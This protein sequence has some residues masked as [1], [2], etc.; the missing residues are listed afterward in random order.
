[1]IASYLSNN[2]GGQIYENH[3]PTKNSNCC[4]L[5]FIFFVYTKPKIAI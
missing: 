5:V 4:M 1:M 2:I 3:L